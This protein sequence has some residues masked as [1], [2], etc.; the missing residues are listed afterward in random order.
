MDN[1]SLNKNQIRW[2]CRRGMLEL[3]CFLLTFFDDCYDHLSL[4]E[5]QDFASLLTEQDQ[6]L[7]NWLL[8]VTPPPTQFAELIGKIH[9]HAQQVL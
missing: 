9:H 8:F 7:Y 3:D 4:S 6:D 2:A 5:K 1:S